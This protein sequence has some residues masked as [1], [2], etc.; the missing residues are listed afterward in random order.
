VVTLKLPL[1]ALATRE[2][3]AP[4]GE[5]YIRASRVASICPREEVL[6]HLGGV[7][8]TKSTSPGDAVTYARGH[9]LHAAARE[10]IL[11]QIGVLYGKWS[12]LDCG[13]AYGAPWETLPLRVEDGVRPPALAEALVLRPSRCESCGSEEFAYREL[14]FEAPEYRTGGSPDGFLRLPGLPGLGLLEL[15][16][17]A[18]PWDV[19]HAP[20]LS[21]AIQVQTYLWFTGLPWAV[22]VYWDTTAEGID[23][24][25][26][27]KLDR[28]PVTIDAIRAALASVVRGVEGGPLPARIC[29]SADC[30][31]AKQCSVAKACF[32]AAPRLPDP[33]DP[34]DDQDGPD[35]W[36]EPGVTPDLA[37][38][39]V[40]F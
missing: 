33:E 12:C 39:E 13:R 6:A 10:H 26:A 22:I 38:S 20:L 15:K 40:V 19:R 14:K 11:P 30:P 18:A 29:S 25:S 2:P 4:T 31:R 16:S 23:A 3:V 27:F 5:V 9:G 8:R 21:H 37:A 1:A 24:L 17:T 34:E 7:E 35:R 36:G 32:E 28:D